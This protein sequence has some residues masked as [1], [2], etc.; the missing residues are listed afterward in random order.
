MGGQKNKQPHIKESPRIANRGEG[1][2]DQAVAAGGD[3][4][5]VSGRPTNGWWGGERVLL[6]L[7]TPYGKR[8]SGEKG[9]PALVQ[10]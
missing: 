9:G 8:A 6:P 1:V 10:S 7:E 3:G 5:R 2:H 4:R